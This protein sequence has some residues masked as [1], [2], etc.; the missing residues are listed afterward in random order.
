MVYIKIKFQNKNSV[1]VEF[2]NKNSID[3]IIDKTDKI[4]YKGKK[5]IVE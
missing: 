5:L 2:N 4:Y 3:K 1:L